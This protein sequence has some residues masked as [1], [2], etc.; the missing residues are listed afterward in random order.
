MFV[1]VDH[2]KLPL[3]EPVLASTCQEFGVDLPSKRGYSSL[4]MMI[5]GYQ[6]LFRNKPR[7]DAYITPKRN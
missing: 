5:G 3:L 2:S 4:E 6:Q 7:T 1:A